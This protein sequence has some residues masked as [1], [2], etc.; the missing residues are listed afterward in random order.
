MCIPVLLSPSFQGNLKFLRG[1]I[2][3]FGNDTILLFMNFTRV[4]ATLHLSINYT[5]ICSLPN[6]SPAPWPNPSSLHQ[7]GR[8]PSV[9]E[10]VPRVWCL[11]VVETGSS[12]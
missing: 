8:V 9:S 2:L 11:F 7:D 3:D 4:S 5:Q 1:Q 10:R 12:P 6:A